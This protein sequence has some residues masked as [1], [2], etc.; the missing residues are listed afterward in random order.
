MAQDFDGAWAYLQ[1]IADSNDIADPLDPRRRG[2]LLAGRARAGPGARGPR[3]PGGRPSFR[4]RGGPLFDGI[5]AALS[6]GARPHHSFA[7]FCIYPWV[8]MLG[9]ARRRPQALRVLDQCRI[10]WG[11]VVGVAAD[12]IWAE[13]CPLVW[14]DGRLALGPPVLE[15]VRRSI[16]GVG[17]G[18]PLSEGDLVALHWD[19]VCDAITP[20]QRDALVPLQRPHPGPDQ[21]HRHG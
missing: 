20:D 21:R 6:A 15:S 14:D 7:V 2:G 9:D 8:A 19:W 10:R 16:D 5:R 3:T 4:Q 13:S 1:L 12:A 18:S 17:L 11:Q